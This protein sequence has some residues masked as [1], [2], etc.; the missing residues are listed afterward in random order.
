M[1]TMELAVRSYN[2]VDRVQAL[3]RDALPDLDGEF[4][5]IAH[6]NLAWVAITKLDPSS[7][8]DRART[9]IELADATDPAGLRIAL[10]ALG[11]AEALGG[12]DPEP[13]MRR[14]AAIGADIAPGEAGHPSGIRAQHLLWAGRI[15]EALRLSRECDEAYAAA[16]LELMRHDSLPVLTEVECAAG[17]WSAASV[18]ADEGYDIVVHA[19]LHEMLDQMLYP[20][21]HVAALTGD[22]ER[23]RRDATDGVARA[24]AQGDLWAEVANR[25]V[26]GFVALSDDD[27]ERSGRG[28]EPGRAAHGRRDDR[29]ARRTPLHPRSR[30][31]A[32]RDRAA[33]SRPRPRGPPLG[34]RNPTRSCPRHGD[35]LEM[36][37][38]DRV[39]VG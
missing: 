1:T 9:A 22:L 21:A 39:G 13:T 7:A 3:L 28:A 32:R 16:G 12:L 37:S 5:T 36:Q 33:R 26:L 19:G 10:G 23:A 14:A 17:D 15:G 4:V 27:P 34:P 25:S 2:D 31:G 24:A 18:H 8:A 20:R 35:G 11:H 38:V 30:R 6:A 29:G